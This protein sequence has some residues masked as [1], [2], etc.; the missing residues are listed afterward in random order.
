MK[1]RS[2][3]IAI[4][5]SI[6]TCGIYGIY[7]LIMLNDETNYVSGHQQDGTSGG[8]VFLLTLVTCGIYGYYW[9]EKLN[10]AKM[11]RGIMVDSSASVLY[12]IL[13]IF[14]L[15]IVSYALMQSELNKML[16]PQ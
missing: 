3:G 9:G 2:V 14:G 12:L 4:L 5:L 6:I 13:S 15:S 8:V 16:P 11:Q 7:W 1:Q 10:E